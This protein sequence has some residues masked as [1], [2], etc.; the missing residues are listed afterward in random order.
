MLIIIN[1]PNTKQTMVNVESP[2]LDESIWFTSCEL[3]I[4]SARPCFK[5][6]V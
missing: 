5:L 4:Y 6:S 2:N 1:Q 3:F